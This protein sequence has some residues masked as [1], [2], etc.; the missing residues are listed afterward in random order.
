MKLPEYLIRLSEED[1]KTIIYWVRYGLNASTVLPAKEREW[2]KVRMGPLLDRLLT[3]EPVED[4][5]EEPGIGE[6][7]S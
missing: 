2:C 7:T 1:R 4:E 3:L 6:P 5:E